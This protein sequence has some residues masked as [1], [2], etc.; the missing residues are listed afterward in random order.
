[1]ARPRKSKRSSGSKVIAVADFETTT[2]AEDCRVWAWAYLDIMDAHDKEKTVIGT[3]IHS[4]FEHVMQ[5]D[6]TVYFHNLAFDGS[7]IIDALFKMGYAVA[8]RVQRNKQFETLI[9]HLGKFY[10]ITVRWSNGRRTEFRDSLKKLPM[11]VKRVAEAFKLEQGKGELDYETFRPVGHVITD[12]ERDYIQRDVAVV[13]QAL[14]L[15]L[16]QGMTRLTVGADSLAQ[17]KSIMTTK[18]FDKLFPVLSDSMDSEIRQAYRGG[19]TYASPRFQGM[20]TRAGKVFDVN[21]LYPSVMYDR[22]LPYGE[23]EFQEGKAKPNEEIPLFIQSITFTAKLKKDH[24][25]CI[26]IKNS[27]YFLGTE[28]LE[29]IDDPQTMFVSNVDLML[30]EQQYD[31]HIISYNGAWLFHGQAGFFTNYIDYWMKIKATTTGGMRQIAKLHLNSL[32]GKFATNPDVTGKVPRLK[33]GVVRLE[34]GP[35]ERR[36][37]VYTAMGVFITSY[38]RE[39]TI[40][41]AQRNYESFAYADTDSLHLL[42]DEIPDNLDVDPVRLGA[43]KH[44]NDFTAAFFARAKCYSE[45]KPDGETVTHIAGLP[46][47]IA[48]QITI[49]DYQNGRV[50]DGKHTPRR[51]KGGIVLENT[52]FTL[53]FKERVRP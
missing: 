38:A 29:S 18:M 28:Y 8:K 41:A 6:S 1:M 20:K 21:S 24:I 26:Q 42:V 45:L 3:D 9:S 49:D 2:I 13:A 10:S 52:T 25:P 48:T 30:W 4:F 16:S 50:F 19:F 53:K 5:R 17:Y 7:F 40:R 35:E 14:A 46:D 39:V 36:N 32:Y 51:V 23:P 34:D 11:S 15:Q 44:E 31:L 33:D 22:V 27:P 47:D 37:P 12:R 43:W